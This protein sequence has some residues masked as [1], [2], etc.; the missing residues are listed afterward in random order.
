MLRCLLPLGLVAVLVV[1]DQPRPVVAKLLCVSNRTG[2]DDIFLMN[3][4]GSGAVNLTKHKA[5]DH[6]PAWSPD[7]KQIAFSSDRDGW[8]QIYVMAA[9][10]TG[11]QRLTRSKSIDR[12]PVWSPDGKRIAF[13]RDTSS[14]GEIVVMKADGTAPVNVTR[15]V[16]FDGD[17]AWSP[18]GKQIAFASNRGGGGFHLYVIDADGGNVRALTDARNPFGYVYPA[19]TP[20]G[21]AI[22][23]SEVGD[24]SL[25]L[26]TRPVAGGKRIPLTKLG[27]INTQ[28]AWSADG[29]RAAFLHLE[30]D[31]NIAKVAS[32]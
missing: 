27:G 21:K 11:V 32:L 3:A 5:D 28:L 18:D 30:A 13:C 4:D 29:K 17:P 16:A 1:P 7:G 26:F 8:P 20:N 22:G 2:D 15:D 23:Y 31:D 25:E 14:N 9:D 19:W 6:F 10:G 24:G 12:A